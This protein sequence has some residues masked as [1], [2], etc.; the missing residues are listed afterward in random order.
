M[1]N[2]PRVLA[3]Q[4]WAEGV[5]RDVVVVA[6]LNESTLYDYQIPLPAPG[7]WLE[8]FNSDVYEAWVNPSAAG[9]GGAIHGGGTGMNGLPHSAFITVPA[10]S[11]LV[12]AGDSGD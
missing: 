3:F 5:G 10:N 1:E 9:N 2:G 6:S 12:F 11:V 8:V 4:R 7:M